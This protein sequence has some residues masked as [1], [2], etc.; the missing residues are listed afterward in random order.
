MAQVGFS[1]EGLAHGAQPASGVGEFFTS[2]NGTGTVGVA[3]TTGPVPFIL[4]AP[5]VGGY[6][7]GDTQTFSCPNDRFAITYQIVWQDLDGIASEQRGP[8]IID[9]DAG[10]SPE[11]RLDFHTLERL[12]IRDGGASTLSDMGTIPAVDDVITIKIHQTG[13]G[14]ALTSIYN[15]TTSTLM[16]SDTKTGRNI[17]GATRVRIGNHTSGKSGYPGVKIATVVY[18]PDPAVDELL[19]AYVP[20]VPA[21]AVVQ[22]MPSF[23]Q[24][25]AGT[26]GDA[27]SDWS[28]GVTVV[29]PV[30]AAAA[31]TMPSFSQSAVGTRT[32][33]APAAVAQTMPSFSQVAQGAITPPRIATVVQT[34][35]RFSQTGT[36]LFAP[37]RTGTCAQAMPSF[38]QAAEGTF[39]IPP[40]TG[41]VLNQQMPSF[42]Q[43]AEG[44]VNWYYGTAQQVFFGFS[45]SAVAYGPHPAKAIA[46]N[47]ITQ[48]MRRKHNA[49][50]HSN[51]H[52]QHNGYDRNDERF[53]RYSS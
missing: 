34:M 13:A 5:P 23:S 38:S 7:Y 48:A 3:D 51:T 10:D 19:D 28:A 21:A 31:Q 1:A 44:L 6:S 18:D 25:I 14:R 43:S 45:Q 53:R 15:E 30:T 36:L 47:L 22:T 32:L 46:K 20:P 52:P 16:D 29:L 37:T 17:T 39:F 50:Y 33:Q 27:L 12:L 4:F 8:T 26:V 49:R 42:S 35:P 24:T 41:S 11:T 9:G 2:L 40:I